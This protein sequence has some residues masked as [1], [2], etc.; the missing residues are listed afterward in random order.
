MR[1]VCC[2]ALRPRCALC[3]R[4]CTLRCAALCATLRSAPPVLRGAVYEARVRRAA[5]SDKFEY[6]KTVDMR[7]SMGGGTLPCNLRM[8]PDQEGRAISPDLAGPVAVLDSSN[9]VI[10]V[11]NVS[12]LLANEYAAACRT[13]NLATADR[14]RC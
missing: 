5:R 2:A 1:R 3:L 12:V 9:A 8:Y 10:S 13:E 4:S 14:C 11:V 6:S 7:P